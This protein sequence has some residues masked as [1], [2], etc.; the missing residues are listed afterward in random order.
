MQHRAE[1]N[2]WECIRTCFP[3]FILRIHVCVCVCVCVLVCVCVCVCVCVSVC[4]RV[5]VCDKFWLMSAIMIMIS[6]VFHT[7][8]ESR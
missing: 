2:G 3:K 4:V 1:C 7:D 8:Q 6:G 5:C